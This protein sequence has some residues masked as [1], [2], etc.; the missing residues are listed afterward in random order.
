MLRSTSEKSRL[1][2][3]FD[4]LQPDGRVGLSTLKLDDSS[5][6]VMR[7]RFPPIDELVCALDHIASRE[8]V[9]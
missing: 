7:R 3:T 2:L 8:L 6:G 9:A 4:L 5:F 1:L